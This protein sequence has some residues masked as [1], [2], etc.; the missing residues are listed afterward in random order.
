M[1]QLSE[2]FREFL[3]Q[4]YDYLPRLL[5]AALVILVGWL[6]ARAFRYVVVR[7]LERL[8]RVLPG[9]VLPAEES[10][11]ERLAVRV[12]G[13][14]VFW[15][16]LIIAAEVAFEVLGL[17]T[18]IT[19]FAGFA[20]YLPRVIAAALVVI[21]GVLLANF[22]AS[23]VERAAR[24]ANVAYAASVGKTVK[25]AVLSIALVV[26]LAQAGL[27]STLL[28][29]ATSTVLGAFLGAIA[30]AFGLGAHGTVSNL[31]ASHYLQRIYAVNQKIRIGEHEGRII[32]LSPTGVLLDTSEGVVLVPGSKFSEQVS[33]LLTDTE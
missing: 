24:A 19:A 29:V 17:E 14:L 33:V 11:V 27:D 18:L 7:L 26:A 25:V 4:V 30:L 1:T 32:E 23:S 8:E 22:S 10:E 16:V 13:A 9:R 2:P 21:G 31:I 5:L 12:V 20:S 6:V 28:V 15:L 3:L